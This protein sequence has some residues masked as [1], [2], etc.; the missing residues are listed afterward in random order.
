MSRLGLQHDSRSDSWTHE[1]I[2]TWNLSGC[3]S[4]HGDED[5]ADG[6]DGADGDVKYFMSKTLT[7]L[8]FPKA[9]E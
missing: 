9:S 2:S 8:L 5:G 7:V 3:E 1:A 6:A 4:R